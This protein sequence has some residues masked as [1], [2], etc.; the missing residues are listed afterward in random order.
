MAVFVLDKRK[1]PLMPCSEKRARLL[2]SKGRAVVVRIYPFTIR[3]KDRIG[4]T[5]QPVAVNWTLRAQ[6][7]GIAVV[8]EIEPA[9]GDAEAGET[10]R[11]GHVLKLL[12]LEHRGRVISERLTRRAAFRRRRRG[13]NLR[14]RPPRFD[15]RRRPE[16]WLPP[17]LQHRVDTTLAWVERLRRWVPVSRIAVERVRF[18]M[19]ALVNPDIE[20]A[21]YQQGTLAG[22]E[23]REYLL[24]KFDRCCVYCDARDTPLNLDHVRAVARGGSS[25]LSNQA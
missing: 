22:Y 19:Q 4:G 7:T 16:G 12:E 15:N 21:D 14:Y 13:A 1:K 25:R 11:E 20:G 17:S 10:G 5:V 23:M 24:E 6:V 9:P 8:R 3:L 2:L 18:D